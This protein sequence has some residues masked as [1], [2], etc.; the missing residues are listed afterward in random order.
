[1]FAAFF[2][3]IIYFFKSEIFRNLEVVGEIKGPDVKNAH[4]FFLRKNHP[5][6]KTAEKTEVETAII[7]AGISGLSAGWYLN[8]NG[9]DD[10]LLFE[11]ESKPGGNC[12][13][14]SEGILSYPWAAHYLPLPTEQS[15]YVKELLREMKILTDE[16]Y[17]KEYMRADP[18]V[19]NFVFGQWQNGLYPLLFAKDDDLRQFEDFKRRMVQYSTAK[20]RDQKKAFSIPLRLSSHDSL[21]TELD[22]ISMKDFLYQNKFTSKRLHWFIEYGLKDDYGSSLSNTSAWAGIHYFAARNSL[23]EDCLTWPNGMGFVSEYLAN[24]IKHKI[25][26]SHLVYHIEKEKD[27]YRI[28]AFNTK[29]QKETDV[30]ARNVIYASGKFTLKKT[31]A[32]LY[33][34]N[35]KAFDSFVYSPWMTANIHLDSPVPSAGD[36]IYWDNVIYDADS[37]GYI[38][39]SHQFSHGTRKQVWTYYKPYV[40]DD[41]MQIR[42]T[43][44]E[45]NHR[46]AASEV[47]D[48]LTVPHP[49]IRTHVEKIDFYYWAHA[50]VR[51]V[52]GFIFSPHLNSLSETKADERFYLAHSDMSGI[53]IFEEAQYQGIEAAKQVLKT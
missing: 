8:K 39:N 15:V 5:P 10:F 43:L 41:T 42:K 2:S 4:A 19:R 1:M 12:V 21:F 34:K 49:D 31:Y 36:E 40:K 37:L 20:G 7:G 51:P 16:G 32:G 25:K 26:N 17:T 3:G 28:K 24:K 23:D 50:M 22:R 6:S 38:N 11:L 53:S 33:Q 29:S 47:L 13:W 48:V 27:R 45:K 35:Q 52:P 18:E 30:L 46:A 9:Y 44:L 14:G